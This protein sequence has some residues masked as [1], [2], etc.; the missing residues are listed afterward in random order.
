MVLNAQRHKADQKVWTWEDFF[1]DPKAKTPKI[2]S[3]ATIRR[4]LSALMKIAI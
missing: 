3:A 1:G 2:H 4:K